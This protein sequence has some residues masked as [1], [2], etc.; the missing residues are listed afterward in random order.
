MNR[1]LHASIERLEQQR[2]EHTEV[3]QHHALELSGAKEELSDCRASLQQQ[4]KEYADVRLGRPA[5]TSCCVPCG[6]T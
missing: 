5:Q 1:E 3:S 4:A 2:T 6:H